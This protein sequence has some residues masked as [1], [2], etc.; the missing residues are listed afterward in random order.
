M[1]QI[2]SWII[3]INANLQNSNVKKSRI[4]QRQENQIQRL[5]AAATL[6]VLVA[7]A[8]GILLQVLLGSTFGNG[9]GMYL[10]QNYDT[11]NWLKSLLKFKRTWPERNRP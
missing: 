3:I 8:A 11:P 10:A 9:A 5:R 7:L 1:S 4:S 2:T 6:G